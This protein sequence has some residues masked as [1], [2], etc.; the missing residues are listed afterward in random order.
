MTQMAETQA[1]RHKSYID[2][3]GERDK[4]FIEFK[5]ME[6]ENNRQHELQTADI[7]ASSVISGHSNHPPIHVQPMKITYY[8][9]SHLLSPL[10][11]VIP[12]Q[13][14][15]SMYPTISDFSE[16]FTSD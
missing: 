13:V 14:I 8:Y 1:K 2:F 15:Q 7:F 11:R 5:K 3:E 10:C 16:I 12:C 6:A 4:R 9:S